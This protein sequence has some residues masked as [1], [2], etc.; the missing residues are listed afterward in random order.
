[1]D[2][3]ARGARMSKKTLYQLFPSKEALFE[4]VISDHLAPLIA[5]TRGG[6]R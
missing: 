3:V 4:A 1:M 5:F 6:G 2:D